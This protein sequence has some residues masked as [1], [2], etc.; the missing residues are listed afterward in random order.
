MT[1]PH[2]STTLA[3]IVLAGVAILFY[4]AFVLYGAWIDGKRQKIRN[5]GLHPV[6]ESTGEV[7]SRERNQEQEHRNGN[8]RSR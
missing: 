6:T 5:K 2:M 7:H 4:G 8:Q 3:A 1:H